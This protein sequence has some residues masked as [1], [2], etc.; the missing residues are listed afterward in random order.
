MTL[1]PF[2]STTRRASSTPFFM[3]FQNASSF[4]PPTTAILAATAPDAITSETAPVARNFLKNAIASSLPILPTGPNDRVI[5]IFHFHGNGIYISFNV[6][7]Y[8]I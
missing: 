4:L 3:R 5:Y 8:I 1:P 2:A 6:A 7:F